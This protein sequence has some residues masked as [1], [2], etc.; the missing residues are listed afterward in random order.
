MVGEG[1]ADP[2]KVTRLVIEHAVSAGG[3]FLTTE[4]AMAEIKKDPPVAPGM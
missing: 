1:I 4:C 2:V 3:T